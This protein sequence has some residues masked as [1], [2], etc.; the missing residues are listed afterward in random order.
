LLLSV[1]MVS[2]DWRGR[3]SLW[4]F[5]HAPRADADT[6]PCIYF[7]LN[8]I[9]SLSGVRGENLRSWRYER[10]E[11]ARVTPSTG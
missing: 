11:L 7:G 8:G 2:R 6:V 3:S 1:E 10:K 9:H 5:L 4:T